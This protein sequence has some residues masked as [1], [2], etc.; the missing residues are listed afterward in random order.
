[1][2]EPFDSGIHL[3]EDYEDMHLTLDQ[4]FELAKYTRIID[5]ADSKEKLRAI[6]KQMLKAWFVQ[7]AAVNFVLK[8]KLIADRLST[9]PSTNEQQPEGA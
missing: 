3:P 2:P 9:Y 1:M 5:A 4:Q 6:S 7:R 8:Q